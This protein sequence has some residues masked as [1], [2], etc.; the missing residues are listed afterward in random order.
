MPQQQ[1]FSTAA[2]RFLSLKVHVEIMAEE[3]LLCHV[4]TKY[5]G[6]P[7]QFFLHQIF[8][9][10]LSSKVSTT[11]STF[12]PLLG[13]E[14]NRVHYYCDQNW[15]IVTAPMMMSVEQSVEC[16]AGETEVLGGKTCHFKRHKTHIMRPGPPR[17]EAAD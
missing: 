9:S 12:L 15:L 13:A 10:R 14:W 16:L 3:V 2:A 8:Y 11:E 5:F 6:L 7:C 4:S 17:W 1:T